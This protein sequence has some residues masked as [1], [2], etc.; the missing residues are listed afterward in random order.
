MEPR[1]PAAADP[2]TLTS[3]AP[4]TRNH[5]RN[6]RRKCPA[7]SGSLLG[8][9]DPSLRLLAAEDPR[10]F[11]NRI[12]LDRQLSAR[13]QEVLGLV[14]RQ[15]RELDQERREVAERTA[16]LD[17][18]QREMTARKQTVEA[19]LRQAQDVV[20]RLSGADRER[21]RREERAE[22]Y[23]K[24][25]VAAAAKR[26]YETASPATSD[27]AAAA[28]QAAYAQL[29]KPYRWA[30]TGPDSFDCSGPTRFV[31]RTANDSLLPRTSQEQVRAGRPVAKSE[32]RPGELVF[33][34]SDLHHVGI[35]IGGGKMIHAPKPGS[36]V[37]ILSID[38][39]GM[40]HMT[41]IRP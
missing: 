20:N 3:P 10:G 19:K 30:A 16:E 37:E 26:Q 36:N 23:G 13:Q 39:R 35:Y 5:K 6:V 40:P 34:Y 4:G 25:G 17:R 41:A 21:L 18:T 22:R 11:L 8:G 24:A 33:F 32:L 7:H 15:R 12:S 27:R 28:V 31:W 9:L 29:G 38:V 2:A 1:T 14:L